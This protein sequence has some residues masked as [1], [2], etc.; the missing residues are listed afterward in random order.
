METS[1]DQNNIF[2][3]GDK[4]S[5][6]YF[7]G[8]TWIKN[9]L[10]AN[11]PLNTWVGNVVFEPGARTN[12]HMHPG[13]QILIVIDGVG[14]YQEKGKQIQIL[15]KGDVVNILPDL[16]HWHGA[17]PDCGFTHI[18]ININSQKGATVWLEKVTDEEYQSL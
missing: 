5:A 11:E 3:I 18:A 17:S 13:G 15:Q 8:T 6:E 14:H 10:P 16:K 2:P 1:E 7:I 9:L 4:A 12:W